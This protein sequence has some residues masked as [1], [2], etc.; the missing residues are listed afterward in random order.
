MLY[1][2][3][4]AEHRAS[5]SYRLELLTF[6]LSP[7][8]FAGACVDL[9]SYFHIYLFE[10]FPISDRNHLIGNHSNIPHL[11]YFKLYFG[12]SSC[13]IRVELSLVVIPNPS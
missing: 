5:V 1:G 2:H 6:L 11:S 12:L 4:A 13:Y 3:K 8:L 7:L 9:L 10:I